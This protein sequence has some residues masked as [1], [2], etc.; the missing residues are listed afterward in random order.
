MTVAESDSQHEQDAE[1]EPD[2][3]NPPEDPDRGGEPAPGKGGQRH[4]DEVYPGLGAI[5]WLWD[6]LPPVSVRRIYLAVRLDGRGRPS[7]LKHGSE[8]ILMAVACSM[9]SCSSSGSRQETVDEL[10]PPRAGRDEIVRRYGEPTRRVALFDPGADGFAR[11]AARDIESR[12]GIAP[13]S[14]DLYHVIRNWFGMYGDYVFYSK[15]ERVIQ[16][17]RRFLD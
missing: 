3:G 1:R 5:Q 13:A 11:R 7:A 17:C 14:Y 4:S 16:A 6:E 9:L 8:A 12:S 2:Q 15:E 10:Y